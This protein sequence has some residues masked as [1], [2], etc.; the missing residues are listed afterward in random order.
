[1]NYDNIKILSD[2]KVH[3]GRFIQNF[4]HP[5]NTAIEEN[6]Y[7]NIEITFKNAFITAYPIFILQKVCQ[8]VRD[9]EH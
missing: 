8:L 1:M 9:D 7:S 5:M 2:R 3:G 6:N 4:F